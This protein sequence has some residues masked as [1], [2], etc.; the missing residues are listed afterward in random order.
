[1]VTS[2]TLTLAV[3]LA[4]QE[5]PDFFTPPKELDNIRYMIGNWTAEGTGMGMDGNPVKMTGKATCKLSMGRW[6]EW[7]SVD[8]MPGFGEIRG[9]LMVTYHTEKK[10]W[11]G[12]WFDNF[13]AQS[14]RSYS[15]L[16]G[17]DLVFISDPMTGMDGNPTQYRI[18]FLKEND[19]K[20]NMKVEFKVGDDYMSAMQ[21]VLT[22]Q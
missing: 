5:Q 3:L 14:L 16:K 2:L 10:M 13:S 21:Y 11:E 22:K 8:T 4:R 1:M 17:S 7:D 19:K 18:S 15:E 6:I 12:I 9:K 20:M